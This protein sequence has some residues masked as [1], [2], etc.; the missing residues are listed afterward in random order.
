MVATVNLGS[1]NK[2]MERNE[3]LIRRNPASGLSQLADSDRRLFVN[4][5]NDPAVPCDGSTKICIP[6]TC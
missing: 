1:M 5:T 4:S 3:D 2:D 6:I